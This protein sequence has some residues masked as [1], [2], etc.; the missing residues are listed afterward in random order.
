MGI[1][2]IRIGYI[3]LGGRGRGLLK[4]VVTRRDGVKVIAVCDLYPDR[5]QQ[6]AEIVKE[7][8]GNEPFVTTDYRDIL[9][10]DEVNVVIIASAWESHV[11]IAVDAMRAGKIVGCEVGGAYSVDDCW[12][13]V[14]VQEET[15]MP[16]MLLENCCFGEKELLV[17]NM[18][19]QGIFGSVVH[20]Q[21]GYRHDLRS[22]ISFGRENRHYRLRNYMNRN[23]DNYPTHDLGPIAK[24]LNINRG[25]RLVSLTATASCARGL[26]DYLKREKGDDYDITNFPFAQGDVITTVIRCA[27][28]ETITLFL[29]TTLPRA[30]SRGFEVHGTRAL[31]TEDTR[32]FF[33]D[34]VHNEFHE[35]ADKLWGNME[36][37]KEKYMHPIWRKTLED[38][39]RGGHGGMDGLEFDAFF[40]AIREGYPM[41]I[42]IYDMATW[43]SITA[44][45]EESIAKGNAPVA[46]P[47]FTNGRWTNRAEE[48]NWLY[49]LNTIYQEENK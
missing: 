48:P 9:K 31:F 28:G 39:L 43:M 35:S 8:D 11:P 4:H 47:D 1:Q 36:E 5:A 12:Q 33:I 46:I 2:E 10:M 26:N 3:G 34:G 14:R 38:G 15:G 32:S 20:C 44:L 16:C 7:A 45:S 17:L 49:N 30:Y 18:V 22:E 6:G 42:D 21:G 40:M 19:R 13:L 41:P 27:H 23:C 25:N 24:I 37:Y 29:D